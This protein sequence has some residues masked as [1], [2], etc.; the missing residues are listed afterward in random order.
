MISWLGIAFSTSVTALIT[1]RFVMG[2]SDGINMTVLPLYVGEIADK[3][4]RGRLCTWGSFISYFG[5]LIVLSIGPFVTYKTLTL[6]CAV[7]PI[8][9][10]LVLSFLPQSPYFLMRSGQIEESRR[11]LRRLLSKDVDETT[12]DERIKEIELTVKSEL[13]NKYNVLYIFS[14]KH[15]RFAIFL[16][17]NLKLIM[18]FGGMTVL[19]SY[20]QTIIGS[21]AS[22]ISPELSSVIFAIVQQPTVLIAG[23]LVDKVGRKV[24]LI[25]STLGCT[26]SL[27]LEGLYFY[28]QDVVGMDLGVI[29]WLPTLCLAVQLTMQPLGLGPVTSITVSE[30]FA[31]DTK[32]FSAGILTTFNGFCLFML[33]K[34]F[35][36]V[37]EAWGMYTMFWI[38]SVVCFY[39]TL[40][41][42]FILPETK[43][44][45]FLEIQEILRSRCAD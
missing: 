23:F 40:F 2:V 4:I 9:F 22:S 44:K 15:F 38:I 8:V 41:G 10:V 27:G 11:N 37:A 28:L 7:V 24:L 17:F 3:D 16:C 19:K 26:I 18:S 35:L 31:D 33:T 30:I 43:G 20:L 34:Y 32:S 5:N 6:I 39:G 25:I 36:P 29:S 21:S 42:I 13:R 14:K 45:S 1:L 12:L